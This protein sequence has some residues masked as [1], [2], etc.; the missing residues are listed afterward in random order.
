M[1]NSKFNIANETILAIASE[2]DV[3]PDMVE[4]D[5]HVVKALKLIA[6]LNG[7]CGFVPVFSGGTSLSKAHELIMRFSNDIDFKVTW[8]NTAISPQAMTTLRNTFVSEHLVPTFAANG[9]KLVDKI[10]K[11]GRDGEDRYFMML[12]E[13]EP[14]SKYQLQ[15]SP[16][17]KIEITFESTRRLPVVKPIS[18]FVAKALRKTPE[19]EAIHCV[20]PLETA[21]DKISAFLWRAKRD[22]ILP[23]A[24]RDA[25]LV[26]HLHDLVALRPVIDAAGLDFF[27]ETAAMIGREG[28]ERLKTRNFDSAASFNAISNEL[29]RDDAWRR[30]YER[31][32]LSFAYG[33][34][35]KR[36]GF[37]SAMENWRQISELLRAAEMAKPKTGEKTRHPGRRPNE[38]KRR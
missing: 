30:Q 6:S 11:W 27:A 10:K 5:M 37:E 3:A 23:E 19:V 20:D 24:K 12:F 15:L 9:L 31:F 32:S 33:D 38:P 26:R 4:K 14:E 21:A 34:E 22:S 8:Q 28:T 18:S 36:I 1:S 13:Y 16:D 2:L 35:S 25:T 7:I 29:R 17:I